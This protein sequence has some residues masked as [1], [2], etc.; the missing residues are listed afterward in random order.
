MVPLA[1]AAFGVA[2]SAIMNGF[3]AAYSIFNNER[4]FKQS[5][6]LNKQSQ[7]NFEKQM[8]FAREQFNYQNAFN[9]NRYQIETADRQAAGLNP[10]NATGGGSV[11]SFSTSAPSLQ[12]GATDTS[13]LASI[14]SIIS[15]E[16]EGRKNRSS[17]E[18]IAEAADS[19][20]RYIADSSNKS[21][22]KIAEEQEETKRKYN[23]QQYLLARERLL[24][25]AKNAESSEIRANA[26]AEVQIENILK[27]SD[28]VYAQREKV[29]RELYDLWLDGGSY[30]GFASGTIRDIA[31]S[32]GVTVDKIDNAF[33]GLNRDASFVAW[34]NMYF[35]SSQSKSFR[36]VYE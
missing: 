35:P 31:H 33:K 14:L 13:G 9:A 30:K 18:G 22:E 21:H 17:Q 32:L 26:I 24:L 2:A 15:Q 10:L 23:N 11:G 28:S 16:R 27:S 3:G 19:T 1:L 4:K 7:E 25:D 12:Q 29:L 36:K 8:A 20:Q 5:E 6:E 34:K